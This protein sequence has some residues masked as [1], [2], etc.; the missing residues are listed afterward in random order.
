MGTVHVKAPPMTEVTYSFIVTQ[1]EVTIPYTM[2][3]KSGR[4]VEGIWTGVSAWDLT[5]IDEESPLK[6]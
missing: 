1:Q 5:A 4:E 3:F 6:E 2:K